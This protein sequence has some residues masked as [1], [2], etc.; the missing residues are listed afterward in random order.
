MVRP[1]KNARSGGS[2]TR[3]RLL[4]AGLRLFSA[5]GFDAVT[6]RQVAA[7]AQANVAAVAYHFGGMKELYTAVIEQLVSETEPMFKPLRENLLDELDQIGNDREAL[8]RITARFAEGLVRQFTTEERMGLRAG[9]VMREFTQPTDAFD[10]LFKGRIEPTHVAVARLVAAAT[11]LDPNGSDCIIQTHCVLGQ[12]MIFGL[13]RLVLWRR[14]GWKRYTPQRTE[15]IV[16]T[17]V[18]SVLASLD[19]PHP[20]TWP[21]ETGQPL[22]QVRKT[23][24]HQNPW[25]TPS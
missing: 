17:V 9:L 14:L 2:D 24:P 21:A 10:I 23:I 20:D 18:A 7:E 8:A 4:E 3:G 12:I 16:R 13:A 22:V 11:G 15:A 5:R 1:E 19:L 6:T 25:K